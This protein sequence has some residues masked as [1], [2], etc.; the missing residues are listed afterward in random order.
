MSYG[1]GDGGF[2]RCEILAGNGSGMR[3]CGVRRRWSCVRWAHVAHAG[4]PSSVGR[5]SRV[6]RRFGDPIGPGQRSVCERRIGPRVTL[7]IGRWLIV[8]KAAGQLV[9]VIE[10]LLDVSWHLPTRSSSSAAD[11]VA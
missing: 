2:D 6:V 1:S 11:G 8:L 7:L 3:D 10:D 4:T 9:G 5:E